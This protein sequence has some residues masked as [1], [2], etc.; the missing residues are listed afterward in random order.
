MNA[1]PNELHALRRK[2]IQDDKD[3]TS[4]RISESARYVGFG[5]AA[6]TVAFLTSDASFPKKLIVQSGQYILFASALGCL[7]ILFD[8]LHY[9]TGYLASEQ[10]AQNR[11]GDFGYVTDS[12]YYRARLWFFVAKQITAVVGA[13]TFI[14]VLLKAMLS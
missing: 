13:V 9:V 14:A 2:R 7:T 10:A 3:F 1:E 4:G 5:L 11:S 12:T 6:L 8:Y